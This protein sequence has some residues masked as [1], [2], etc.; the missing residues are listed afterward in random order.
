MKVFVGDKN[1][2]I[3][4]DL[5][6]GDTIYVGFE[7]KEVTEIKL[8][9]PLIHDISIYTSDGNWYVSPSY[10]PFSYNY[11]INM[12][13]ATDKEAIIK[14]YAD[15]LTAL[16]RDFKSKNNHFVKMLKKAR[17]LK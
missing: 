15:K 8:N 14:Y 17:N 1:M 2:K 11:N 7:K 9:H 13:I 3:F 6:V 5:K 16:Q 12:L 10:S 4:R